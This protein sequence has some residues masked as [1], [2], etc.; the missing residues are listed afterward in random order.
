MSSN[1]KAREMAFYTALVYDQKALLGKYWKQ[2]DFALWNIWGY[3]IY[4]ASCL[5]PLSLFRIVLLKLMLE[6]YM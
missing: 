1:L 5:D 4:F 6:L 3:Y 2:R